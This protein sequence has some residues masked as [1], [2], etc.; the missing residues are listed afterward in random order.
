[1]EKYREAGS[2]TDAAEGGGGGGGSR[3]SM[4]PPSLKAAQTMLELTTKHMAEEGCLP[5]TILFCFLGSVFL[6]FQEKQK[7]KACVQKCSG[8][9]QAEGKETPMQ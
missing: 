4:P 3:P 5:Q 2:Y 6:K 9:T 7:Q 1:M 8:N